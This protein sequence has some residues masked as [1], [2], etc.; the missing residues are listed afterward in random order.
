MSDVE[1]IESRVRVLEKHNRSLR[2]T[3]LLTLILS[4]LSLMWGRV[5]PRNG[6][7]EAKGF[8]VTDDAGATRGTFAYD[9]AGVGL[10][11]QDDRGLWRAGFL[12]DPTGRPAMFLLDTVAQP[13]VTLNLQRSGAPSLRMRTPD[14]ATTLQVR[15]GTGQARGIFV[16]SGADTAALSLK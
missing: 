5:W 11:L 12:V 6:V 2:W 14:D 3:V 16:A 8:V 15:L 13:V 1:E 4:I 10:N 9:A 7:I